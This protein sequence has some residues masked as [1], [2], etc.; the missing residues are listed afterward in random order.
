[1][2]IH[3]TPGSVVW[4][5][6]MIVW[7]PG[8]VSTPH[9][10]HCVQLVMTLRGSLCVRGGPTQPRGKGGA[11]LVRPDA[12]HEVDARGGTVLIAFIEAESELGAA[13]CDEIRGEIA[14]VN[15]HRVARWR[16][17]LGSPPSSARVAQWV[18]DSLL[19]RR[20][21]VT[22]DPRIQR[23]MT[24]VRSH[25]GTSDSL[26]LKSLAAVAVMSP[27]RFMHLFTLSLGVPVRPY[28]RWLRLQRAACELMDGAT[29][30]MAAHRAGFAD[31]AHMTRTFR[32]MLGTTPSDLALR[33]R[34]AT[35]VSID[36]DGS[37]SRGAAPARAT[38][39][40][41]QRG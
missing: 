16:E 29:A 27:S 3:T 35:G 11:A 7:G 32:Y 19:Q 10:H 18:R 34:L 33:N 22:L 37:R 39:R 6:A 1:M 25:L 21:T 23:V 31:A 13:L 20:R 26:S 36:S 38:D 40:A 2:L 12:V 41:L 15:P 8:F 9:R 30:S 5:A 28:I 17:T 14:I 24:H 4:P